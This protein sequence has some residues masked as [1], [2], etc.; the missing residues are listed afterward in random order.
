MPFTLPTKCAITNFMLNGVDLVRHVNQLRVYETVCK[1]YLTASVVI[2]DTNNILNNMGI[3][4]GEPVSFTI[5][6]TQSEYSGE[7]FVLSIKGGEQSQSLRSQLYTIN[8]IGKEYF[9]DRGNMV[10]QSF[11][12]VT[13]T[14]II[15]KIHNQFMGTSLKIPVPSTGLIGK[16]NAY[17]I[18]SAKPFKAIA[19]VRKLLTFAQ[20]QT[21]ASLYYRD[22]N[23][24]NIVPLEHLFA[25]LS[26][27]Q[28]FFQEATWGKSWTDIARSE[29]SIISAGL[30]STD[31]KDGSGRA[32][33]QD[34][35]SRSTGE[36]K[37]LDLL[38]NKK[39][40][41]TLSG[42]I[43]GGSV[44]GLSVSNLIGSIV[45]GVT[46]GHG[47]E[48]NYYVTDSSKVPSENTRQTEREKLYQATV[49]NG[50]Q[51]LIKVPIQS[52]L[53]CTVGKGITA[54][55]LPPIG[56]TTSPS[57][58][59]EQTGGDML[60]VDIMHEVHSDDQMMAGTTTFRALKGGYNNT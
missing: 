11:K 13:G 41:D 56:D 60:V 33:I 50:P 9:G 39:V 21:G 54:R 47:G 27:Q 44:S 46:G 34:I 29:N 42:S 6:S 19:D 38:T 35:S 59:E 53:R 5:N 36:R 31:D 30:T 10:Q 48:H 26:S 28:T 17:V 16:D 37:V 12:G 23:S 58:A 7:F 57:F 2:M 25:T 52:G 43:K 4:G 24:V 14:D 55:L 15:S 32:S 22:V 20:Y 8:L 49:R 18:S 51:H 3:V 45:G 40:F 1:P